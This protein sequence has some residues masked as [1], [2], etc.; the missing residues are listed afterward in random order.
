MNNVSA[1]GWHVTA[2][3]YRLPDAQD[4]LVSTM[5][6]LRLCGTIS[7]WI[8]ISS[9]LAVSHPKGAG[10][11][12]L[13][14][15]AGVGAGAEPGNRND[16]ATLELKI[17]TGKSAAFRV[18]PGGAC[19]VRFAIV[20]PMTVELELRGSGTSSIPQVWLHPPETMR[21][22][23]IPYT[24]SD[25]GSVRR[26]TYA[27]FPGT[28]LLEFRRDVDGPSNSEP[29]TNTIYTV[30]VANVSVSDR[31]LPL[32][33]G[34]GTKVHLHS[35]TRSATRRLVVQE[36]SLVKFSIEAASEPKNASK[37]S[38]HLA[39]EDGNVVTPVGQDN[40]SRHPTF[41]LAPNYYFVEVT[42]RD[43]DGPLDWVL[44]IDDLAEQAEPARS[45]QALA[46]WLH[47]VGLADLL[48]VV[49]IYDSR[50]PQSGLPGAHRRLARFA[51]EAAFCREHAHRGIAISWPLGVNVPDRLERP[52]LVVSFRPKMARDR[53]RAREDAFL[54]SHGVALWDRILQKVVA[55]EEFSPDYIVA[56]V[57]VLCSSHLVFMD[58]YR[59]A[60]RHGEEC[61][62]IPLRANAT[63]HI[64]TLVPL[65]GV[66]P[67]NLALV[68]TNFLKNFTRREE[69]RFEFLST[70]PANIGVIVRG[71]RGHVIPGGI[72]WERL[73]LTISIT[74]DGKLMV[75]VSGLIAPG[76]GPYPPDSQ[77]TSNMESRHSK[78]LWE[79]SQK[80]TND[81]LEHLIRFQPG[82][83]DD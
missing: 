76:L 58:A 72:E 39:T 53:F 1:L 78:N 13:T 50:V 43:G 57:P 69:A 55:L 65:R 56:Y 20:L 8:L 19:F 79:Y 67:P 52:W 9:I 71:L 11:D 66:A 3:A 38:M 7:L 25:S 68:I 22:R 49:E 12:G 18:Q 80:L 30:R 73:Q 34:S 6:Q 36:L 37:I 75:V 45:R 60:R 33:R 59:K 5:A 42:G 28:F 83:K 77:F 32:F 47:D 31:E 35:A 64:E 40:D 23:D 41:V 14:V 24:A 54:R 61:D 48:E 62:A 16:A 27:L 26:V 21:D 44:T 81:L 74:I 70:Q 10:A 51:A 15:K 82:G 63:P 46:N 2:R 17:E 29:E 4:R